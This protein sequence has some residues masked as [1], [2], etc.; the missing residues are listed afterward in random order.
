MLTLFAGCATRPFV[1]ETDDLSSLRERAE[2]QTEGHITVSAAVAGR[3]EARKIFGVDLYDDGV[4]PV[5]IEIHN[6]GAAPA[7]YAPVSTDR[8]YYSP[9]EVSYKNRGGYTTEARQSMDERF[10]DLA[11]TR[12]VDAGETASG[13]VFTHS[14]KGLSLIHI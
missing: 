6:A 11:M 14:R 8:F 9:L 1:Y 13:F 10:N 7:R 5:W 2:T 12:Y 4:Q 3:D